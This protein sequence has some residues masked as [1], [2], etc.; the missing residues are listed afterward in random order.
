MKKRKG[1]V[2]EKRTTRSLRTL[3]LMQWLEA[4]FKGS[5]HLDL[6]SDSIANMAAESLGFRPNPSRIARELYRKGISFDVSMDDP[7][8]PRVGKIDA[9]RVRVERLEAIIEELKGTK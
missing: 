4:T 2:M 3:R 8:R 5:T 1:R 9:L 6:S 7:P